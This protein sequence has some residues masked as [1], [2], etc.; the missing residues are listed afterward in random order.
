[1]T[2]TAKIGARPHGGAGRLVPCLWFNGNARPAAQFYVS[3]F[4]DAAIEQVRYYSEEVAAMSPNQQQPGS[5]LAVRF[6]LPGMQILAIN[7]GPNFQLSPA[8]SLTINCDTQEQ[9]NYYHETLSQGGQQLG[10]GWVT[11][12]FG[13][14]WQ[15][16]WSKFNEMLDPENDRAERMLLALNGMT[17]VDIATLKRAYEG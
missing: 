12:K 2:M 17:K 16:N 1:M 11:D 8:F 3:L 10:C 15:I 7:G 5:V 6:R 14:S 9:I 13:M 4:D